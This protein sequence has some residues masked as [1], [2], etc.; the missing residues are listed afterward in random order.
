MIWLRVMTF[1]EK[2]SVSVDTDLGAGTVV[3]GA[4]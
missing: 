2:F 1:K 3:T 4:V